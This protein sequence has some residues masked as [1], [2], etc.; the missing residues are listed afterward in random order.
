M[1]ALSGHQTGLANHQMVRYLRRAL[2]IH[3]LLLVLSFILLA[4]VIAIAI[5]AAGPSDDLM[6]HLLQTVLGRY[7]ETLWY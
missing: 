4:P 7:I 6:L 1:I 5:V 3:P 2:A